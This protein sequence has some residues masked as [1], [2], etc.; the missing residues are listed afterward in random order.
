MVS[1]SVNGDL[2]GFF[3]CMRAVRQ[4]DPLP[5]LLFCLVEDVLSRDLATLDASND[6]KCIKVSRNVS[7]PSHTLYADD[8]ML[9]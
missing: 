7:I 1:V 4:G 3:N 8:I 2:K 5:P 9:F 6:L